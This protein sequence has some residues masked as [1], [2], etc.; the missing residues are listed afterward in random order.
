MSFKKIQ[1]LTILIVLAVIGFLGND[2]LSAEKNDV[3]RRIISLV[4]SITEALFDLDVGDRVVGNTTYCKRPREAQEKPKV[5]TAISVN[6]EQ[7]LTLRPDV[8]FASPLIRPDEKN[9]LI[10]LGI[11][12]VSLEY[13]K[14]FNE[15]CSQFLRLGKIVGKMKRA[16]KIVRKAKKDVIDV[17]QRHEKK[18]NPRVFVQIGAKPLVTVNKDSF[19]NDFI[20]FA[21]GI[22][23]T[24]DIKNVKYSKEQVLVDNPDVIITVTMGLN[25]DGEKKVW[26]RYKSIK[27]IVSNR[28]YVMDADLF[29]SPTPETFAKTLEKVAFNIHRINHEYLN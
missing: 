23:I 25:G 10:N 20:L 19:I 14:S 6:I 5:G 12:V 15:I 26:Q 18:E 2:C 4:P 8:V 3:P 16:E 24:K 17:F 28:I 29:C 21:G 13:P 1:N 22:N 27:A 11:N 7:V 9:K